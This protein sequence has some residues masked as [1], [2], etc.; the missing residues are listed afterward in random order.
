MFPVMVSMKFHSSSQPRGGPPDSLPLASLSPT[1][2]LA[3]SWNSSWDYWL[4]QRGTHEVGKRTSLC[5]ILASQVHQCR[6]HK[7]CG[8]NPWVW[9]IH[10]WR[11]QLPTLGFLPGE[12]HGQRSL[13]GYSPW[14]RTV[15][16]D[17]AACTHTCFISLNFASLVCSIG[18]ATQ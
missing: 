18:K 2:V 13:A 5:V 15:G 8:F 12:F 7:R 1:G 3:L 17:L 9:K 10:W 14:G 4:K 11:E 6:K 16:H